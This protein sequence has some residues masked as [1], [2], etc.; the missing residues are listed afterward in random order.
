MFGERIDALDQGVATQWRQDRRPYELAVLT[1][2]FVHSACLD[3]AATMKSRH[4]QVD[5]EFTAHSAFSTVQVR[6]GQ[7]FLLQSVSVTFIN[8][9]NSLDVR[10]TRFGVELPTLATPKTPQD[11][12]ALAAEIARCVERE[13][14][15]LL[16]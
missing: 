16:A 10:S 11:A 9:S 1:L 2:T 8:A 4:R 7:P 14:E 13:V 5:V 15:A 3:M 12:V 6:I